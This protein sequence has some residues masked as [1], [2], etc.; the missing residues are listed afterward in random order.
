MFTYLSI[1]IHKRKRDDPR[2][3]NLYNPPNITGDRCDGPEC[4]AHGQ[5]EDWS[6]IQN[7]GRR[8]YLSFHGGHVL[9]SCLYGHSDVVQSVSP[10]R[11][12]KTRHAMVTKDPNTNTCKLGKQINK[13]NGCSPGTK[14]SSKTCLHS[15]VSIHNPTAWFSFSYMYLSN[16]LVVR[17]RIIN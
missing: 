8:T 11:I 17:D 5:N 15:V 13:H 12:S 9:V 2:Q 4:I 1:C 10:Y 14:E 3:V 7:F 16:L 6:C